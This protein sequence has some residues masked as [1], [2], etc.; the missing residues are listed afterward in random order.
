MKISVWPYSLRHPR[1]DFMMRF[2]VIQGI[3][4]GGQSEGGGEKRGVVE[5]GFQF[6]NRS[7]FHRIDRIASIIFPI[8]LIYFEMN[9]LFFFFCPF[10][11]AH[12]SLHCRFFSRASFSLSLASERKVISDALREERIGFALQSRWLALRGNGTLL[13][14][15]YLF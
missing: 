9:F 4:K 14:S 2:M 3:V 1:Y 8:P 13:R 15:A 5:A 10:F 12:C 6:L 7:T 11:F